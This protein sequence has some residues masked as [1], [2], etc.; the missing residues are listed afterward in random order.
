V[1]TFEQLFAWLDALDTEDVGDDG[2]DH[3]D[4]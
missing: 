3:G 2:N 1:I 4:G